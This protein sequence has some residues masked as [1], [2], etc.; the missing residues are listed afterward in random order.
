VEK[1]SRK[2][3]VS[4]GNEKKPLR[5]GLELKLILDLRGY[6]LGAFTGTATG[7]KDLFTQAERLGRDFHQF[8]V[9]D[10]FQA[11]LQVQGAEGYEAYPL[12]GS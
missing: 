7:L 5:E 6:R 1:V 11:L 4:Q 12:V 2:S 9:G 8:V 3:L 10:E